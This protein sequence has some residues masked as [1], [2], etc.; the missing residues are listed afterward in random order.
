MPKQLALNALLVTFLMLKELL[1]K[2]EALEQVLTAV[3]GI[4]E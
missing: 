2:W 1:A 3:R 4:V